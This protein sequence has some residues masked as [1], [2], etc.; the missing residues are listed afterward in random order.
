[1]LLCLFVQELCIKEENKN[2]DFT[3]TFGG[4]CRFHATQ[5]HFV[6]LQNM[7]PGSLSREH[8]NFVV[9]FG[10]LTLKKLKLAEDTSCKLILKK[11]G[12]FMGEEIIRKILKHQIQV[13]NNP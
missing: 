2:I 7:Y 12:K 5:N 10:G 3:L 11:R 6:S 4:K 8:N 9:I 13:V 1:M